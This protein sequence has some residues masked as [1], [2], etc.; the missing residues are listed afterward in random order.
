MISPIGS[1]YPTL[2]LSYVTTNVDEQ[3]GMPHCMTSPLAPP[4]RDLMPAKAGIHSSCR[5]CSRRT[6]RGFP[7]TVS[8]APLPPPFEELP[9]SLRRRFRN[10]RQSNTPDHDDSK[11]RSMQDDP[12]QWEAI[13]NVQ[14]EIRTE[15]NGI[16]CKDMRGSLLIILVWF[17]KAG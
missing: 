11:S 8:N 1:T 3:L 16:R 7:A 17:G 13:C 9:L 6:P 5:P 2:G 12:T 15:R 10:A 4:M 14:I